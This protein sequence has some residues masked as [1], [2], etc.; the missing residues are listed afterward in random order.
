MP[1]LS[2]LGLV[3]VHEIDQSTWDLS[4]KNPN[5]NDEVIL[6]E[7]SVIIEEIMALDKES[8]AILVEYSGVVVMGWETQSLDNLCDFKNGLW[9]GKR[10]PFVKVGVIRNTNFTKGGILDDSDIAYLEVEKKQYET[11]RLEF[12]DLIL[13]RSGGGPKQAVGRVI[14]FEKEAG[15]FSFSNFTSIIRIK[16][17][18]RLHHSF[19]HKFYIFYMRLV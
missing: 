7:P 2:N 15:E 16:D 11:R 12:G 17:K 14:A 18:T 5:K 8:E 19:L 3:D 1:I 4:V 13:E 10:P 6:R 9:K